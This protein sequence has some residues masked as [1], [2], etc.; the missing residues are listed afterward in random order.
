MKKIT[1]YFNENHGRKLLSFSF[2]LLF[3]LIGLSAHAQTTL[4]FPTNTS[5]W[6]IPAGVTTVQVEAWGGGGAGGGVSGSASSTRAGGG[7]SGGTYTKNTSVTVTPGA[8]ITVTVGAGGAGV[9]AADGNPGGT[10]TFASAVPVSAVGGGGGKLGTASPT[11]GS[12]GGVA[13]GTTWAGGT[14]AAAVSGNSGAGGGGAGSTGAGGNAAGTTAGAAGTG[15]GG[16]GAAGRTTN[17]DG[18]DAVALSGGGSGGRSATSST[19]R[20]GGDGFRGQVKV[21][22]T[23]PTYSLTSATTATGPFCGASASV[24]TV[25]STSVALPNGTYT[26]TYNLT[27]GNTATG[28]TALMTV[29]SGTGTFTTSVL[30]PSATATTVAITNL[31]SGVAGQGACTNTISTN[32]TA[33]VVVNF[34]PTAVAGSALAAICK[35]GT[36]AALG[37]SVG[38]SA[39]AG[40]WTVDVAGGTFSGGTIATQTWTPPAAYSG[41]ATF[42]LTTSGGLC[43]TTTA[44]KTLT[45]NA[46]PTAVAGNAVVTCYNAGAVNITSGSSATNQTSVLWTSSGNGT[47]SNATSLT[48]CTYTPGSADISAGSATLTLTAILAGCTSA[49]ST[50]TITVTSP[51]AT[52]GTITGSVNVCQTAGGLTYSIAAIP[53]ATTYTWSVPTGWTI[54]SGQG[55]AAITVTSGNV[56]QD[57][58]VSVV[59][60]NACGSSANPSLT[61]IAD[62]FP[63]NATN[64]TGFTTSGAKTDGNMTV[65][66]S[67]AGT[68]RYGYMK[69]PL[70]ELPAGAVVT[71]STLSLTNNGSGALSGVNNEVNGIN[72]DPVS[73]TAAS[74]FSAVPGGTSYNSSPWSNTG[75]IAL[76]L[77][78]AANADI[79]SKIASGYIAMG[80]ERGAGTSV[81][82]FTGRAGG[83]TAPKL[84][85]THTEPRKLDVAVT[86]PTV[87]AGTPFTKSCAANTSGAAIGEA[88][89]SGY[90]YSW[91]PTIGLSS[92][93]ISNPIANPSVTTTYTVTKT[94]T[95]TLCA[96]EASVIVTVNL[97]PTTVSVSPGFTK[98]CNVNA[99]GLTIGETNDATATYSWT[100]TTGLTGP[101]TSNPLANPTTTTTYTV[102]KTKT[103]SGCTATAQVTVT[104]D[105]TA[106][107]VNAGADFSKTCIAN[108]SGAP[109]GEAT[110]AGYTY[111]WSPAT[112]LSATNVS[113]PIANP[114][115]TQT[116]TLT[117]TS[118]ANGCSNTDTVTVTVNN[119]IT[120]N[121]GTDFTKTCATNPTGRAIG[122]ATSA[123]NTYSWSP[124]TGLSNANISNPT[125][126]PT[127]T[128]TY[129]VTR[130]NTANGCV[131][132]DDVVVTVNLTTPTADAGADFTKT[133]VINPAGTQIG[134]VA[135]SGHTYSW[136][137]TIGLSSSTASNP[138][139]N[140]TSTQTYTVTKRN[141]ASG[142]TD[143]DT[144]T[145]TVNT[146]APTVAALTGTQSI[147]A[148]STTTFASATPDGV[149]DSSDAN[150]ASVTD[151]VITAVAAG[152]ADIHYTV[153]GANGCT[154]TVSR[155]VTVNPLPTAIAASGAAIICNGS[156]TEL[157]GSA[158]IPYEVITTINTDNFNGT[159]AYAA[160]G[161][162]QRP[163]NATVASTAMTNNIDSSSFMAIGLT[164]PI[165]SSSAS[166]VLTSPVISTVGHSAPLNFTFN[167]S[168]NRGNSGTQTAV[169]EVSTNGSTWT[170]VKTYTG[171]QGGDNNFATENINLDA[172]VNVATLQIRITGLITVSFFSQGWWVIDNPTLKGGTPVDAL[173]TWT[174]DT[175]S[176][177]NGLP[178][179]A[180]TPSVGNAAI[181]VAPTTTTN[182]TLVAHDPITGCTQNTS[183][184][185]VTVKPTPTVTAPPAQVFCNGDA[186]SAITLS[187]TPSG[188]TYDISGGAAIGLA[189]ATG[190]T[191]IAAYTASAGTALISI[192]PKLNGCTGTTKT[193]TVTV[194]PTPAVTAPSPQTYCDG[195]ATAPLSLSGTPSGVTFDISGGS[196]IGLA[197]I[198]G[199]TSVPS[200]TP[201][202]GSA[203]ITLI[204]H[205]NGCTGSAVTFTI[206]VNPLIIPTFSPVAPICSGAALAALPTT[207]NNGIT[208]TWSPA[209]NN[210][211]TTTYTFTPDSGCT[212]LTLTTLQIVVNTNT[213]YYADTDHDGFGDAADSVQTCL[214]LPTNFVLNNTDCAPAD[215]T[216]WRSGSFYVDADNDGFY[217]GNDTPTTVCYGASNP[218]GYVTDIFGTDCTDNNAEINPNHVEVMG[219]AIDDNCDGVS[220]EVMHVS[221][222]QP[223]HCGSTLS[224]IS[225]ILYA[226]QVSE[227]TGYRFEVTG[228][229][230]PARTY[231]SATINFVLGSLPGGV[232]YATTY[233]IRVALKINGFWRAYGNACSVTTPATP[234]TTNIVAA[235]CGSTLTSLSNTIY[236]NQV[237]AAN[238]Y[239]FEVSDGVNQAR[240]YDSSLNRFNLVNVPGTTFYATTYTVRVALRFGTVWQDYGSACNI[241]T[242]AGPPTSNI[243]PAQCGATISNSWT[244]IYAV[245]ISEAAAYRF[246][247]SNGVTT[248]Y[249]D[250]SVPRFNIHQ[251]PSGYAAGTAYTIRVAILFQSV[252]QP[253]GSSCTINTAAALAKQAGPAETVFAVKAY[254]NPYADT[255]K[256]DV[257]TSSEEQMEV[258]V[259]DMIGKL[260]EI[261]QA[262]ATELA[263]LE[264]GRNYPSGV[265][266]II[267][268]QGEN[269]KTLR[270]I[271]R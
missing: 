169:V 101:T 45:V 231:D 233:S 147:C 208:G 153:T 266:N 188:V 93:T 32:N 154:T 262:D 198:T 152:N 260:I 239:R 166:G 2:L 47:F 176:G 118:A 95:T 82:I 134:E 243:Q 146:T 131:D 222:L 129:T 65:A 68:V 29:A 10:S 33:S 254:P 212:P 173:Y 61:S 218:S 196:A 53:G 116:Y 144:V 226:F 245:P 125:A 103:G 90:S 156:S 137:P 227:A 11:N 98:T 110:V 246:E 97:T 49:V 15:G 109:I 46:P 251:I 22:Y 145:V 182:Y 167:H 213:T 87:S 229:T 203:T 120:A 107:T 228:P 66:S 253:F 7:G 248:Q 178:G 148:G 165:G 83:A 255:F 270:V 13:A 185:T 51:P 34:L 249:I 21:T 180:S 211:L 105:I 265:Y 73:A 67:S 174:A 224:N 58:S 39:T 133:C 142:C 151:G 181:S 157:S 108:V 6:L 86:M 12:G 163:N 219:N 5:P 31:V 43:G 35:G 124:T 8:N 240:T 69:F 195:Y 177:V 92:S 111:S 140:P 9:S 72:I 261:R 132:S 162:T 50:K 52:A 62:I 250:T 168:Y 158:I 76:T 244:T 247:V 54:N 207:S 209:L 210:T 225:N 220:D 80:L 223:A 257:A 258:K 75:T 94:N 78:A 192:T 268:S 160:T 117:K 4:T 70:T 104:V 175:A 161:F 20:L 155:T 89:V 113:N 84:S 267:V 143:T 130:T 71:A 24:I 183:A 189:D 190:V 237:A 136:L 91:N 23:C 25:T 119:S 159:P 214:G 38:G 235:Q 106:P 59:A 202:I 16:I 19:N 99:T 199:V 242:P 200:F 26:V 56:G 30:N 115:S 193:Y 164:A 232:N 263:A 102:V 79:Q 264:V 217:N 194:N 55:T 64:N 14:G 216:K 1:N 149:W 172:Y 215:A 77:N 40:V 230:G 139:A 100:P 112:G 184:V 135:E 269:V 17:G 122:E 171:D 63:V 186:V 187:G 234:A 256:L 44:T 191:E 85:V 150:I 241:T 57:G 236:C 96:A 259:Y 123:G 41:T 28:S 127:E 18:V 128:T 60:S 42:T 179:S 271:K 205:A 121:A 126:N 141:T 197:D 114:A 3:S 88:N 238:Q 252:Y 48:T 37:G 201:A 81:Y 138:T 221:Y 27:G 74:I 36:S 206:T 204:P 170:N